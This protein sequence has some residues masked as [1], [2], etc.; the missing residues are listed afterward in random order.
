MNISENL[1]LFK[2]ISLYLKLSSVLVDSFRKFSVP[3]PNLFH[4]YRHV[5]PVKFPFLS[6][7][8]NG[9]F[10]VFIEMKLQVSF[11]Y[12]S[13]LYGPNRLQRLK[14]Y[15]IDLIEKL[16]LPKIDLV[17]WLYVHKSL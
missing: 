17:H 4:T 5:N 14:F 3:V 7:R 10:W 12:F 1:K 16:I 13:L 8:K 9:W 11:L 15:I 2:I 6:Y